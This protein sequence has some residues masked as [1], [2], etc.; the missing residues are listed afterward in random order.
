MARPKYKTPRGTARGFV[1]L[2]KEDTTYGGYKSEIEMSAQDAQPLID[3]LEE[4]AKAEFG[5]AKGAKAQ[6][7]YRE[8]DEGNVIFKTKA[9]ADYPPVIL[10]SKGQTI[11]DRPNIGPGSVLRLAGSVGTNV[12]KGT[13]YVSLYINQVK[14]LKL[15]EFG[16][17]SAFGD[18]DDDDIED[19]Y[20]AG[21]Q[22]KPQPKGKDDM[23]GDQDDDED[24]GN[25]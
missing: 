1:A 2:G 12:V 11:E 25:F 19:A 24:D 6:F 21:P 7:P 8:T 3:H 16:G 14:L 20:V 5:K 13:A 15:V 10:D 18:D 23:S 22:S 17:G 4:I 9:N